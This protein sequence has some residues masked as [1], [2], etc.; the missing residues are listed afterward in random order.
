MGRRRIHPVGTTASE[1]VALST[2]ALKD[3]G[4]ARKTF[5]LKPRAHEALQAVMAQ[6]GAPGTETELIE[7]LLLAH[8]KRLRLNLG[9]A[10]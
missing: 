5:R 3:A 9:S 6:P 2:A 1:R 10:Q 8:A 4:G 7:S